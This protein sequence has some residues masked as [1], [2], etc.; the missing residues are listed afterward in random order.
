MKKRVQAFFRQWNY[1][2]WLILAVGAA[3]IVWQFVANTKIEWPMRFYV[4]QSGSMEPS[5]MTGDLIAVQKSISYLQNEVITFV[6]DEERTVTHRITDV[7]SDDS[8]PRY[9][10]KGDANPNADRL[11]V[12]HNQVV[13]K[14]SLVLPKL[15]FVAVFGKSRNGIILLIVVPVA[16]IIYDEFRRSKPK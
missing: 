16:L 5:I 2:V 9:A 13:G 6:D 11:I 3:F 14:V 7:L 4:V 1:W 8:A 12:A 15:G 10:T